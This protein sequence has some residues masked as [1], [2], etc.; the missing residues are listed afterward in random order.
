MGEVNIVLAIGN[1]G[2]ACGRSHNTSHMS[3]GM[4]LSTTS[5][6]CTLCFAIFDSATAQAA[7]NTA[8]KLETGEVDTVKNQILHRPAF[9]IAEQTCHIQSTLFKLAQ[10]VVASIEGALERIG[11]GS[12]GG[13]AGSGHIK[14]RCQPE[15]GAFAASRH[16][17]AFIC[18]SS[19]TVYTV[20]QIL[21]VG[22]IIHSE[23]TRRCSHSHLQGDTVINR[24]AF[25]GSQDNVATRSVSRQRDSLRCNAIPCADSRPGSALYAPLDAESIGHCKGGRHMVHIVCSI[26]KSDG[27]RHCLAD[28]QRV[29]TCDTGIQTARLHPVGIRHQRAGRHLRRSLGSRRGR[30]ETRHSRGIVTGGIHF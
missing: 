1:I 3:V 30:G 6:H 12:D 22:K 7:T 8:A 5:I 28:G 2:G 14:I 13:P 24:I 18:E 19:P 26:A 29:Q 10:Y 15:G 27:Q 23:C 9:Y 21:Q 17:R 20:A 25:V 16:C 11:D 4:V